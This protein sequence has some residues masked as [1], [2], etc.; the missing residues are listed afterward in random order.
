[1]K[2]VNAFGI[3]ENTESEKSRWIYNN[4]TRKE[5]KKDFG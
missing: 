4:P 2:I 3:P 5:L 1:M